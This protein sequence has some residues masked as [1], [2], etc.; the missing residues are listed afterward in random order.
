[1]NVLVAQLH[2]VQKLSIFIIL[3]NVV[4]GNRFVGWELGQ[5]SKDSK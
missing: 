2:K 1:M 3:N 4:L 5:S